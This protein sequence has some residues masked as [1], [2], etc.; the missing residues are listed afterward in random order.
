MLRCHF[1]DAP[2]KIG[3]AFRALADLCFFKSPPSIATKVTEDLHSSPTFFCIRTAS[4]FFSVNCHT[5]DTMSDYRAYIVGTDGHFKSSKVIVAQDDEEAV[6]MAEKYC[7][8]HA[9]EVW[10]LDRKIAVLPLKV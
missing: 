1:P 8:E 3:V 7:E 4:S 6:E 9:V 5:R 2:A 10:Q